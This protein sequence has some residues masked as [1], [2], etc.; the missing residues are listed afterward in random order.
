VRF[1]APHAAAVEV[2]GGE[3]V[4]GGGLRIVAVVLGGWT[5]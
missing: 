1:V 2:V 4:V 3:V 5:L